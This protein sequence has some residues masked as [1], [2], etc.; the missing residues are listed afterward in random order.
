[1]SGEDLE[2]DVFVGR[3]GAEAEDGEVGVVAGEQVELRRH[4][5][6]QQVRVEDLKS[7]SSLSNPFQ[8]GQTKYTLNL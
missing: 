6:V 5:R 2:G 1:M 4:A 3:A 8:S 7:S